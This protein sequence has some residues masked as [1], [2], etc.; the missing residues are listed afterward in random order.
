MEVPSHVGN[1]GAN[2]R[3][4]RGDPG[5]QWI[6]EQA[7]SGAGGQFGISVAID[8]D[9]ALTLADRAT[10]KLRL[11]PACGRRCFRPSARTRGETITSERT[12]AG[13][14]MDHLYSPIGLP[15]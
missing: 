9:T 8:G 2:S 10:P 14:E 6:E 12:G 1:A 4:S 15:T 5:Q 3:T 13:H 7:L 11:S